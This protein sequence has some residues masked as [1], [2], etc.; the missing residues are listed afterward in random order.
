MFLDA[1]VF[2]GHAVYFCVLWISLVFLLSSFHF[3]FLKEEISEIYCEVKNKSQRTGHPCH[4]PL[5]APLSKNMVSENLYLY[6]LV[7]TLKVSSN[8]LQILVIVANATAIQTNRISKGDILLH[9]FLWFLNEIPKKEPFVG[10]RCGLA[11]DPAWWQNVWDNQHIRGTV[12]LDS[13][14]HS[15]QSSQ[16]FDLYILTL[17]QDSPLHVCV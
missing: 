10:W 2:L 5:W 13:Q 1:I 12:Y 16:V 4:V 14:A 3:F 17:W 15:F 7:Y 11:W 6:F 9:L 8:T